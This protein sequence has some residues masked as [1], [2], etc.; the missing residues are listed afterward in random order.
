MNVNFYSATW[1]KFN[2]HLTFGLFG[3]ITLIITDGLLRF[4]GV[5][6]FTGM[7]MVV[8]AVVAV[9]K[10]GGVT[11]V[12]LIINITTGTV[13]INIHPGVIAD[14]LGAGV[15]LVAILF[16]RYIIT[17]ADVLCVL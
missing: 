16:V 12:V 3:S 5:Y 6:I 7:C 14:G 17:F 4:T 15:N 13:L 8:V 9:D 1:I 10:V 2:T 11:G